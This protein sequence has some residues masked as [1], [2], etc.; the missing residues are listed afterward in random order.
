[1]SK[2]L[3]NKFFAHNFN[4]LAVS[5]FYMPMNVRRRRGILVSVVHKAHPIA[6]FGTE[7]FFDRLF[8]RLDDV[9]REVDPFIAGKLA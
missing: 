9:I 5:R 4:V 8:I 7:C 3:I 1:M 6:K 2:F